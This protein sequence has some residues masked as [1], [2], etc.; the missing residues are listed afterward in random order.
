MLQGLR[1]LRKKFASDQC[2]ATIRF[3]SCGRIE[4]LL[5]VFLSLLPP[6]AQ[7]RIEYALKAGNN[8]CTACHYSPAGGGSRNINGK[9]FGAFG[10]P[11]LKKNWL[12]NQDNVGLE[13]KFLYYRP[14]TPSQV[15]GG[16]GVMFGT[17][18]GSI[19]IQELS[20]ESS[21]LRLVAEQNLGGFSAG[22]RQWY[23]RWKLHEDTA[24]SWLP[25]YVLLGRIIPAFG[26]L[27]DEHRTYVRIQSGTAWQTGYDTGLMLS[28]NPFES[29]HYDV[30]VVN[31]K[32]NAGT[33]LANEM[34]DVWGVIGNIRWAPI[35]MPLFVG[36][37][38]SY[39]PST[40]TEREANANSVYGSFS[41]Y[42]LTKSKMPLSLTAEF[43]TAKNWNSSFT[44]TFVSDSTYATQVAQ[45]YS[46]GLLAL[47]QWD[48]SPK[49]AI[50]YKYDQLEL[51]HDFPSDRYTRHG[52]GVKAYLA[53]NV[54]GLLRIET[55]KAG[56][57]AEAQ[58]VKT[59]AQDAV[60][61]LLNI[62][63]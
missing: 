50:Q 54:F 23:A 34:A 22:P 37:S 4:F 35:S 47:A 36:Y 48:F 2:L 7:G 38:Q 49:F 53:N 40:S 46:Y 25:Q 9:Y 12:Q 45:A 28:A 63:L 17:V 29:L 52:V 31:G 57:P 56:H 18:W 19:E 26:V 39:Y 3:R 16:M 14:E 11:P 33:A 20:Q 60:W 30:A 13:A 8:R 24:T 59:G 5:L 58:G 55:A 42:R 27:T 51:N 21:E 44:S 41:F 32:K 62:S 15:R 10:H 61:G 6:V 1:A 43:V